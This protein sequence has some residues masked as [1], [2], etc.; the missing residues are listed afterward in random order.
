VTRAD[1][2]ASPFDV[3]R[4]AEYR[5][6]R[7]LTWGEAVHY[8]AETGSTNDDALAAA[9]SGATHGSLFVADHQTEGR[10][11]R[12]QRWLARP[13]DN[14]L[15][16]V[17]LRPEPARGANNAL[18]LA[19]GLGVRAALAA[20][21]REALSVK[22]P[23]DVL[24]GRRKLAGVL[25]EGVLKDA[26]LEALVIGVGINVFQTTFPDDLEIVPVSLASLH[27]GP[28]ASLSRESLLVEV[29]NA[30]D[31]RVTTCLRAG[32]SSLSAEFSSHDALA[33]TLVIVS[34]T[35]SSELRGIARGIDAEGRLLVEDDG[36][37]IP[38]QSG[39]VRSAR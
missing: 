39:T 22:W 36:V 31:Q 12:G 19:V 35:G 4:F 34:G 10:G 37:L 21:S 15:F 16:S 8:R 27:R 6:A 28:D 3:E 32:L 18:T 29:L 5:L 1:R 13:R 9:R 24:A 7:G 11:R 17:L 26:R 25:C 20:L 2:A 23:N 33:G 38:V 14:L 30:V